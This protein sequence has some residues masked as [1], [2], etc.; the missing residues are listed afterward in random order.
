MSTRPSPRSA[1]LKNSAAAARE[2]E[3]PHTLNALSRSGERMFNMQ[4]QTKST[5]KA[6]LAAASRDRDL[7]LNPC[8]RVGTK[9]AAG[10]TRRHEA[11]EGTP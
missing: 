5:S 9:S 6:L 8:R 7:P 1:H 3:N 11:G 10:P 2:C 4:F